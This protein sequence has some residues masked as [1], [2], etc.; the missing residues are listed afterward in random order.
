MPTPLTTPSVALPLLLAGDCTFTLVS[1]RTATRYTFNVTATKPHP[2]FGPGWFVKTLV[3]PDQYE[4]LGMLTAPRAG[5][6]PTFRLTPAST[7]T[8]A[9]PRVRGLGYL[10]DI[11]RI[12]DADP[13]WEQCEVWHS[14]T[15]ARCGRALTDPD[16]IATRLGPECYQKVHGTTRPSVA[17]TPVA[18]PAAPV[19]ATPAPA[20]APRKGRAKAA[21]A[22]APATVSTPEVEAVPEAPPAPVAVEVVP[23]ARRNPLVAPNGTFLF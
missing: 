6:A 1:R 14:D 15:C 12:G 5:V 13:R 8:V 2:R 7:A 18:A 16:S 23:P 22:G 9:D 19:A 3:A 21:K 20:A 4:Y 17:P 11:L 10:F